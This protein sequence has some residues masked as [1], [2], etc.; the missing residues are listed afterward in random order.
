MDLKSA[1][2]TNLIPEGV[3]TNFNN[4]KQYD[5]IWVRKDQWGYDDES[6][7][8]CGVIRDGLTC[9]NEAVSDHCPVWAFI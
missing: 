1:G 2:Y 8:D 9:D 5:N 7:V 6:Q 3:N 4:T